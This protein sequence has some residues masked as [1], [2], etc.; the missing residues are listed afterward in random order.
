METSI[1]DFGD[2]D[3]LVL[4]CYSCSMCGESIKKQV[5]TDDGMKVMGYKHKLLLVFF[6][7]SVPVGI[8]SQKLMIC[9][10][11]RKVADRSVELPKVSG[12]K[13]RKAYV[14]LIEP[15]VKKCEK[16]MMACPFPKLVDKK[17]STR[18]SPSQ[19]DSITFPEQKPSIRKYITSMLCRS[20]DQHPVHGIDQDKVID[21]CL[22]MLQHLNG[23][24]GWRLSVR[25][26]GFNVLV[27]NSR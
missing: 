13:K 15:F 11:C 17:L 19:C 18:L 7:G 5:K 26:I 3:N 9:Q 23:K 27:A 2:D 20:Y 22:L 10:S 14:N 25:G 8:N 24:H 1:S 16:H 6:I 21:Q 12:N 4:T